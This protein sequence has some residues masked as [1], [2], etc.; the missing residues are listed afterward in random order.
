MPAH[1]RS[2]LLLQLQRADQECDHLA[3]RLPQI[4]SALS[5]RSPLDTARAAFAAADAALHAQRDELQQREFD[6]AQIEGKHLSH[7]SQLF[8]GRGA[9]RDLENLRKDVEHLR[10]QRGEAEEQVLVAMEAVE[11]ATKLRE[12]RQRD[13]ARIEAEVARTRE[14]MAA[15]RAQV[16]AQLER[17]KRDRDALDA[18]V[19]AADRSLYQRL[20]ARVGGL[21]VAEAIQGRCTGCRIALP[22]TEFQRA[23]RGVDL[24]QCSSC[25]RILHVAP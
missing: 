17:A 3:Q 22:A 12:E 1:D 6:L 19:D 15:E 23:R 25:G 9:P 7:E 4:E 18:Q 10:Q 2:R 24:V 11:E 5:D 20:R 8:G 13:A 14:Q 16:E 21:A